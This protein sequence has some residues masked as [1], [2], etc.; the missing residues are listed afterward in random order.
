MTSLSNP[1]VECMANNV[2]NTIHSQQCTIQYIHNNLPADLFEGIRYM[3]P[4]IFHY[5]NAEPREGVSNER[6]PNS[7]TKDDAEFVVYNALEQYAWPIDDQML[8]FRSF[9]VDDQ[10]RKIF[11]EFWSDGLCFLE[12]S[13]PTVPIFLYS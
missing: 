5:G 1:S 9:C 4:P 12:N 11:E 3:C 10:K 6:A 2:Y 7:W 8:A 13:K